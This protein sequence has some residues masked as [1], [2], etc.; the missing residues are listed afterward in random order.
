VTASSKKSGKQSPEGKPSPARQRVDL[1][2]RWVVLLAAILVSVIGVLLF[3]NIRHG[4]PVAAPFTRVGGTTH[5]ETAVDATRFWLIPPQ[6]VVEVSASADEQTMLEGAQCAMGNDAPLLFVPSGNKAQR[7]LVADTLRAWNFS[8]TVERLNKNE[9]MTIGNSG[10]T[11]GC[12]APTEDPGTKGLWTL[13]GVPRLVRLP[14]D[15]HARGKLAP[16]VVF[17]AAWE[18]NFTPDVA[19]GMALSAH[20]ASPSRSV[21]LVVV[22]RYL[23]A[24]PKLVSALEGQQQ[25]V[26]GGVVLGEA[27]TVPDDTRA[28]LRQLLAATDRQGLLKQADDSLG[29]VAPLVAALL[30]LFGVA[31]VAQTG[32]DAVPELA[33]RMGK[34]RR[35]KQDQLMPATTVNSKKEPGMIGRGGR[36]RD[37]QGPPAGIN[38]SEFI[39]VDVKIIVW[40]HSGKRADGTV[41]KWYPEKIEQNEN[42]PAV[43][44][45]LLRLKDAY[46]RDRGGHMEPMEFVLI[47]VEDI[48][49][50]SQGDPD[51]SAR[52][53]P[54]VAGISAS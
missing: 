54:A 49:L 19:I 37:A 10:G 42:Q 46:L 20:M 21:S 39:A 15:I 38:W 48:E 5:V 9:V 7:N 45:K 53:N 16:T 33:E 52:S 8:G 50:I 28:L 26:A 13:S 27:E 36:R 31:A 6:Y 14:T 35:P 1:L 29:S 17:A 44:A 2:G 11:T 47:P 23:E 32:K 25:L 51:R 22:P 40:L 30:A 43:V 3:L 24:D 4:T 12:V 18:P 34:W 41:E